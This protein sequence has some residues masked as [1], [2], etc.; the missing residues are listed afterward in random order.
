MKP[1]QKAQI[2]THLQK[3]TKKHFV[4]CVI[5][6][7]YKQLILEFHYLMQKHLWLHILLLKFKIYIVLLNYQEYLQLLVFN[8]LNI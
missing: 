4:E 1:E 2:I 7:Y 5:M 6:E 8:V 3:I